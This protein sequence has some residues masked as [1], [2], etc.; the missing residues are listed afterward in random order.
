MES[1]QVFV[2]AW[3]VDWCLELDYWC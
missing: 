1:E 2:C 3:V